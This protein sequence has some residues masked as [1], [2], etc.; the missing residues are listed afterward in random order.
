MSTPMTEMITQDC[1]EVTQ[2]LTGSLAGLKKTTVLITGGTGFMGTWLCSMLA[3]LNDRHGWDTKIILLSQS[4]NNFSA[5][6]PHLALRKDVTLMEKDVRNVV[7]IDAD[8]NFIIHAA[9][10]PDN[11]M[12]S[13]DPLKV[14]DIIAKGTDAMLAVAA[15]LSDLRKFLNISSGL[16][17][18]PQ[19]LD[20]DGLSEDFHSGPDCDSIVSVYPEAKR[21]A[22]TLSAAYRTQFKIPVVT[23]RPFAFIGPYQLLDKPWAVNNFLRDSLKGGPIRILGDEKT[24]RSYMYPS[25]MAF[26]LL[27]ILA[28]GKPGLAYNVGSPH[29]ITLKG[30][31]EKIAGKFPVPPRIVHDGPLAGN[32]RCSKFVPDVT[33][34]MS[35]LGLNL[36]V[37]I[38]K[39]L[40]RTLLW[41]KNY[42][43]ET[44]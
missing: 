6:A 23:A 33:R 42:I 1:A 29:A 17:Y 44:A 21:F 35:T 11:R 24:V 40:D 13:S 34:A 8:V 7:D 37:D 18:G 15:R 12:H 27:R 38:D 20:M 30:L 9:A 32:A 2:G 43:G 19:P 41:H 36:K 14:L 5:K 39:A 22:E 26:W 25:D 10:S 4:A 16:I 3:F 28:E 31:A